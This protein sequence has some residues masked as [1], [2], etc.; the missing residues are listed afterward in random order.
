[1]GDR[2]E[3]TDCVL[4]GLA[5]VDADNPDEVT[6]DATD[7]RQPVQ[8]TLVRGDGWRVTRVEVPLTDGSGPVPAPPGEAPL[9][10]GPARAEAPPSCVLADAGETAVD[11]YLAFHDA[12]NTALGIGSNGPA[13]P[14][15]AALRA[16]AVEP[17][18]SAA[19]EYLSTLASKRQ[20]VRGEPDA[21]DPWPVAM[22]DFDDTVF[23]YDCVTL[24]DNAVIEVSS[25]DVIATNDVGILRLDAA[26]MRRDSD[27]WKAVSVSVIEEGL[28]ECTS[29]E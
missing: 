9:L 19:R 7:W 21:R 5:N 20:A 10:R 11:A 13:D 15:T 6:A 17:Q 18:L 26:E 1:D 23:V 27:G 24:G 22:L 12:Y 3:L 28:E 2:A 29:P 14:D 4:N 16:T 8:A 25:G